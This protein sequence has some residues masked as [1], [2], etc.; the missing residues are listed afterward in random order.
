MKSTQPEIQWW[1]W[2]SC[3][4][5]FLTLC[6]PMDCSPLASS[7][8]GIS[9]ARILE[10]VAI[11]FSRGSSWPRDRTQVPCIAGRFFI[12]WATR[13]ALKFN[14]Q[15]QFCNYW[16]KSL[17]N[18]VFKAKFLQ[19]VFFHKITCNF[20]NI[21]SKIKWKSHKYLINNDIRV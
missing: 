3:L 2:F 19:N 14:R 9:Q 15:M 11:S 5:S 6:Y 8:H 12:D 20:K 10:W 16:D 4:V 21:S 18:F 17:S 1:W 7:V 13:E